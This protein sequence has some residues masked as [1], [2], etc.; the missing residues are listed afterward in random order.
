MSNTDP[1][2]EMIL[3]IIFTKVE[4]KKEG[5][6]M[7]FLWLDKLL[8]KG[9]T[10]DVDKIF[11]YVHKDWMEEVVENKHL[12]CAFLTVSNGGQDLLP[13]RQILVE[14]LRDKFDEEDFKKLFGGLE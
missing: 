12:A 9:F 5:V 7:I 2:I 8:I 10:E 3:K 11:E 1:L 14:K 4:Q 13:N 6:K